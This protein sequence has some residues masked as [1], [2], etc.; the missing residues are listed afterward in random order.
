MEKAFHLPK[1]HQ[2]YRPVTAVIYAK[3]GARTTI[4]IDT[5][6]LGVRIEPTPLSTGSG[7]H[8]QA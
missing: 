4:A 5:K 8:L 7:A 2:D 6:G 3:A 1:P